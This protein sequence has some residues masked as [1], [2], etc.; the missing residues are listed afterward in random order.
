MKLPTPPPKSFQDGL[1]TLRLVSNDDWPL[2]QALSNVADVV[3]WTSIPA[4]L[5]EQAARERVE[6]ANLRYLKG[7]S[8]RYVV[9]QDGRACGHVGIGAVGDGPPEV[10]YALLPAAR[11]SGIA[12]RSIRLLL[13]WA[14]DV[15]IDE[16][17]LHTFPDNLDSQRTATRCGFV[18][19]GETVRASKEVET[20]LLTWSHHTNARLGHRPTR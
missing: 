11:G 10:G 13:G 6:R 3:T 17:A 14:A 1:L 4:E 20:T 2:E 15:G 9:E 16:V 12:T 7:V 5:S 8:A 19:T 18:L